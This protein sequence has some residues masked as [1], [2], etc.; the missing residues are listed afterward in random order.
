MSTYDYS[1]VFYDGGCLQ[2]DGCSYNCTASHSTPGSAFAEV[3]T[4]QDCV[5]YPMI[6]QELSV[7]GL[8]I[9]AE[10]AVQRFGIVDNADIRSNAYNTAYSC[11]L[12]L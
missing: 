7:I 10:A 11:F 3:Y 5:F 12:G 8:A 6:S 4:L 2:V 9:Q 1:A